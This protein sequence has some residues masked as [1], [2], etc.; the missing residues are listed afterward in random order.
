MSAMAGALQ[1][2]L[3]KRGVY[4][5]EGGPGRLDETAIKRALRVADVCTGLIVV[6]AALV[7]LILKESDNS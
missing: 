1:V 2:A 3:D 6:V 7:A 5:L 4:R